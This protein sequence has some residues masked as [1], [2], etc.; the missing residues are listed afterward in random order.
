MKKKIALIPFVGN[1]FQHIDKP[2]FW[3]KVCFP[4]FNYPEDH[5]LHAFHDPL[6]SLL[7]SSVEEEFS[8]F[9]NIGIGF[10]GKVELLL[11]FSLLPTQGTCEYDF[12]K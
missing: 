12:S 6:V 10:S 11:L 1:H 3:N 9:V 5:M 7:Q 8:K 2:T 4:T